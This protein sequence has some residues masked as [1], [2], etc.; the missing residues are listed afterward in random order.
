MEKQ[1]PKNL[2]PPA[3]GAY[4]R[5]L[6]QPLKVIEM[7]DGSTTTEREWD[8]Q[9]RNHAITW[10]L[11]WDQ[12][13]YFEAWLEYEVD[14]GKDW[15]M[16]QVQPNRP[17]MKLRMTGE[18]TVTFNEDSRDW[19]FS[20]Q[21]EQL[22]DAPNYTATTELPVWPDTLPWMETAG[23][24]YKQNPVMRSQIPTGLA[25]ERI[26][27]S[28]VY[29]PYDFT[30]L[31]DEEELDIF[32]VFVHNQLADAT[33]WFKGPFVNGLG[34]TMLRCK[35][36]TA[37]VV[38]PVGAAFRVT[39]QLETTDAPIISE[40]NYRYPDGVLL[41]SNY[42]FLSQIALGLHKTDTIEFGMDVSLVA[43]LGVTQTVQWQYDNAI[44]YIVSYNRTQE[45]EFG[46]GL[47]LSAA[48]VYNP[49]LSSNFGFANSGLAVNQSY[50]DSSYLAEDYIGVAVHF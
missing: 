17:P 6:A 4:T 28:T 23:Y 35:F 39:A 18:R 13:A 37:P 3:Q 47:Q 9:P 11:D 26:R 46:Y 34:G 12:L 5:Q 1:F 8:V 19:S 44:D 41:Q 30:L 22:L 38:T 16:V 45:S 43:G 21:M 2:P 49:T 10:R 31:L 42:G 14:R 48:A 15:F 27:F 40:L 36:R 29:T 24:G 33:A 32:E 50:V 7:D 20:V 25:E